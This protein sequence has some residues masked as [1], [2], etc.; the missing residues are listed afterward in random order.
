MI[1]G[2]WIGDIVLGA[3]IGLLLVSLLFLAQVVR[4][5]RYGGFGED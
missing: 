3:I 2:L 1:V 5:W 4:E